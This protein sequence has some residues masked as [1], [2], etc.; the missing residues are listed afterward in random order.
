MVFSV[1]L[2]GHTLKNT[3]ADLWIFREPSQAPVEHVI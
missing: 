1:P 2:L 3:V